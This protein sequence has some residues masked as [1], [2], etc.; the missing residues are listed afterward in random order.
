MKLLKIVLSTL[1]VTAAANAGPLRLS[2]VDEDTGKVHMVIESSQNVFEVKKNG[3]PK[4]Y[5]AT[6]DLVVNQ[7]RIDTLFINSTSADIDGREMISQ[8]CGQKNSVKNQFRILT[9]K[10]GIRDFKKVQ[11]F[12]CTEVTLGRR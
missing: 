12:T 6:T 5:L 7:H 4:G 3:E 11:C 8:F 2:C 9:A 10:P 1:I